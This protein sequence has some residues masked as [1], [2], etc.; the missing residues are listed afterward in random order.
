MVL[1]GNNKNKSCCVYDFG[2]AKALFFYFNKYH[3]IIVL[4][5]N[6]LDGVLSQWCYRENFTRA[7]S[8]FLKA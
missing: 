6:A 1:H 5:R 8:F 4:G 3:L 7:V 2:A